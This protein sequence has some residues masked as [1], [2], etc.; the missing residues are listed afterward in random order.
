MSEA[1]AWTPLPSPADRVP[2]VALPATV[3]DA[4][5]VR[6]SVVVST[7][8]ALIV[9]VVVAVSVAVASALP[10][11]TR[12]PP[13]LVEMAATLPRLSVPTTMSTALSSA[14]VPI[15]SA[16]RV[17]TEAVEVAALTSM[18]PPPEPDPEAVTFR[19]PE[20][21]PAS[22]SPAPMPSKRC[23]PL[24]ADVRSST[25]FWSPLPVEV[26]FSPSIANRC[27]PPVRPPLR[28]PIAVPPGVRAIWKSP[29]CAL[30]T[31]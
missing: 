10:I 23:A 31:K 27:G 1:L 22:V 19:S 17:S 11:E 25:S 4:L 8:P 16:T 5:T 15:V 13:P 3:A 29:A 20:G 7:A 9:S 12:P 2:A 6:S 18:T 14:R 26:R 21:A 28:T 30:T 24:P